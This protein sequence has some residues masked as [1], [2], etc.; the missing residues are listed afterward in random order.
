M[1]K[2]QIIEIPVNLI[3]VGRN[4]RMECPDESLQGL[5][6]T[7][8]KLGIKQ[9]VGLVC[10]GNRY[11]MV[12]GHRRLRATELAG[13][14]SIPARIFDGELDETQI[15]IAQLTENLQREDLCDLDKAKSIMQ[16]IQQTGWPASRVAEELGLRESMVSNLRSLLTLPESVQS[17]VAS[18]ALPSSTAVEIARAANSETQVRL[19]AEASMQGLTRDAV[20]ARVKRAKH[21][22][23]DSPATM[24]NRATA[25]LSTG[26]TITVAGPA[27][28]LDFF[29]EWLEELLVKAR[30][31][32]PKGMT[33][34]TFCRVLK[35]Q[36]KSLA[37]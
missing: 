23:A 21:H 17:Q 34:K 22:E 19:A 9:P 37:T 20:A 26:R 7:V 14:K 36:A 30:K 15:L 25:V 10:A 4:I 35:E 27:L 16:L 5:A 11:R 13:L 31:A 1:D 6:Q 32:R 28:T 29:I 33:L 2:Q 3:D 12:F 18:G 8:A 24:V